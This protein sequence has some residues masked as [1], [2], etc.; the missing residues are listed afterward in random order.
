MCLLVGGMFLT[1][2]PLRAEIASIRLYQRFGSPVMRHVVTCRFR[3]TCS[4]YALQQ[5][6]NVGFWTGNERIAVRL[7]YCSPIGV[8]IDWVEGNPL[9]HRNEVAPASS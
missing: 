5:L 4:H 9:D 8:L 1:D 2:W 3:P 6:E 7:F